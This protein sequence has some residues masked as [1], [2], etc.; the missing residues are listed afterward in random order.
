MAEAG[1]NEAQAERWNAAA[2]AVW[3]EMREV[4]DRLFEPIAAEVV[5]AGFP[6]AGGRVLDVG[7]G[8]GAT[9]RAMARRLG[10]AG[11]C[12]GLDISEM[13]VAEAARLAEAE[14]LAGA[15]FVAGDA[16][17][18]G[19]EAASFD[20][21]ISR[22]GVMF[23]DDPV[24]AFRN[25]RSAVRPG[26]TLAFCSWRSPAENPF[27]TAAGR[28]ATPFLPELAASD[29]EAPG[30]FAFADEARVRRIL[31]EAGWR[32]VALRPL[33]VA[34]AVTRPVL[35]SFVTRMG[36]VGIALQALDEAARAPIVDAVR[37][38]FE[39]FVTDG[40]A[41]FD[42]ACWLVTARA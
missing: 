13:L 30:Q 36:P 6:G 15:A 29:P 28:A 19:F 4:L 33:D 38:A 40:V 18:Y 25:I 5:G 27:M 37:A 21:A 20:A 11:R 41:R 34:G 9:T 2:G 8:A 26:G 35:M 10:P 14:G 22:F 24:A 23:F 3:I 16:Q 12:Q 42:M 17:A 1:R 31:A 39:P 32:D 7:C